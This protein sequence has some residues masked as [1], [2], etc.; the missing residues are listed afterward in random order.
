ML[1]ARFSGFCCCLY[2]LRRLLV[3]FGADSTDAPGEQLTGVGYAAGAGDTG[4]Y[5]LLKLVEWTGSWGQGCW[6]HERLFL[7][8]N[9][10]ARHH[11]NRV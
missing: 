11:G 7:K 8:R 9:G 3:D 2:N 5:G 1:T 6:W 10:W 4:G